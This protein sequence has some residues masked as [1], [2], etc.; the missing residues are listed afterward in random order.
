[1]LLIV[2]MLTVKE[3]IVLKNYILDNNEKYLEIERTLF[4]YLDE[5]QN[6]RN[7]ALNFVHRLIKINRNF[8]NEVFD[9]GVHAD[10]SR[11]VENYNF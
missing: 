11:E 8:L 10:L 9:D 1:M 3:D 4:K 7:D 2:D 5:E 6:L